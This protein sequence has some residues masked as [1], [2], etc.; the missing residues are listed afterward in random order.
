MNKEL[1]A[2]LRKTFNKA[3][4]KAGGNIADLAAALGLPRTTV[5]SWFARNGSISLEN[6]LILQAWLDD[7]GNRADDIASDDEAFSCDD[8]ED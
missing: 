4:A 6:W 8:D 5:A 1:Q 7:A 2:L 3:R